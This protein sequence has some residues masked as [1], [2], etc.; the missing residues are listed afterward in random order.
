MTRVWNNIPAPNPTWARFCVTP[1]A[2]HIWAD[3]GLEC[4]FKPST[5]SSSYG[6]PA[7]CVLFLF[8][9]CLVCPCT[10]HRFNHKRFSSITTLEACG[11]TKLQN[12]ALQ[13]KQH[14]IVSERSIE[15]GYTFKSGLQSCY[16]VVVNMFPTI[17]HTLSL[18]RETCL[19][20][21]VVCV[22]E[23]P[24]IHLQNLQCTKNTHNH[25]NHHHT[26]S[27]LP[28]RLIQINRQ[29]NQLESCLATALPLPRPLS[30]RSSTPHPTRGTSSRDSPHWGL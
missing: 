11:N 5:R 16:A 14:V 26:H 19:G 7:P 1:S 17:A 29:I 24:F 28:S 30:A 4:D 18:L 10:R 21:G 2:N 23:M 25:H 3:I 27:T 6:V 20:E 9:T 15:V 8:G 13:R 12:T 22:W